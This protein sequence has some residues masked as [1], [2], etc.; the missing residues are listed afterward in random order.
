MS[1][2]LTSDKVSSIVDNALKRQLDEIKSK[3][4]EI[5][6]LAKK[7]LRTGSGIADGEHLSEHTITGIKLQLDELKRDI[8]RIEETLAII[9]QQFPLIFKQLEELINR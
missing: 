8:V 3:L 1:Q 5:E 7:D 2:D 4:S 6:S 9:N